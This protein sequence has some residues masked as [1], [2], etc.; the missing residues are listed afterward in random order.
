MQAFFSIRQGSRFFHCLLLV[1]FFSSLLGCGLLQ[2]DS[3]LRSEKMSK[4]EREEAG[5]VDNPVHYTVDIVVQGGD[6]SLKGLMAKAS[7]LLVNQKKPPDSVLGIERR[8]RIDKETAVMLLQAECYYEGEADYTLDAESKPVK[9]VLTLR[10]NVRYHVGHATLT[11]SPK[12]Y[13]SDA[14]KNRTRTYGLFGLDKEILPEPKFPTTLPKV[15]I[16]KP[17]TA[18]A[19]LE[20]VE[21]FPR[22]LQKLGYPLAMVKDAVYTLDSDKKELNADILVDVGPCTNFGEIRV[23]GNEEVS[24]SFFQNSLPWKTGE[25]PWDSDELDDYA[26]M[27]RQTGLFRSVE[28]KPAKE[29]IKKG[30]NG[31]AVLPIDIVVKEGLFHT[32]GA[33]A[34]YDTSTGAGVE[35]MWEHRNLFHNGEKLTITAPIATQEQGIKMAFE[36][37]YFLSREQ[38]LTANAKGLREITTAYERTGVSADANVERRLTKYL[39]GGL[40]VFLDG[41]T[42]KSNEKSDQSYSAFGPQAFLRHDS[43]DNT[44]SP[45]RGSV[46]K[47]TVKPTIGSYTKDFTALIQ[48]LGASFYYAP[49]KDNDG[50]KKDDLVFAARVEGGSILGADRLVL[51]TS[52]RTYT[53]GAGSV[54]GYVYQSIGPTDKSNDPEGGRSYQYVNLEAR[55]KLTKEIGIVPFVDG[56]MAYKD[57]LPQIIGDMRWGG[58]IGLRYFTPIGPLR[59]DIATPFNPIKDDPPVQI[60][61]SIGQAF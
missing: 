46:I 33:N 52:M 43:R 47:W 49:F 11:Y 14:L 18:E 4:S 61:V 5:L 51:P 23:T 54:R 24:S 8:A 45:T 36:K 60:Y 59:L 42:L 7:T 31:V 40:G 29:A 26:N 6:A 28:A 34:H 55:Y 17:I 48:S 25:S 15:T 19:M 9:V 30:E 58:G 1:F 37:P 50:G 57:S 32:V 53:G 38:K 35:L 56:G 12:P 41:G 16:G 44:L 10:P 27:L 21:E 39:W 22:S 3:E 20:A 13:V 2:K